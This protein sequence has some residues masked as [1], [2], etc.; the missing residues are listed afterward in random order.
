MVNLTLVSSRGN[1]VKYW[2]HSGFLGLTPVKVE[3]RVCTKLDSDQKLLP[4]KSITVSVRC[5]ESRLG[6]IGAVASN[7]LVD[8]TQVLWSKPDGQEYA[9]IGE[10]EYPFRI[11]LPAHVGGFSTAS[12][13]EYR[14][15]WRVEA[16]LTHVHI[17][18]VG[19]R[20]VK[21]ANLPLVRYDLPPHLPPPQDSFPATLPSDLTRQ[22]SKPRVPPL[23]YC[24]HAPKSPIGP[25]D[26]V[27]IQICLLPCQSSVSI[28]SATLVIERRLHLH[29][30]PPYSAS[31]PIPIPHSSSFAESISYSPL[32]SPAST[33]SSFT[34]TI[35]PCT[36]SDSRAQLLP[37]PS[38]RASASSDSLSSKVTIHPIAAAE[39]TGPFTRTE[40]GLWSK[41]L[42]VQWPA[43]KSSGRW[44]I[45]ETIQSE[46]V[47]V[48]FVVRIKVI[49]STSLGT[50]SLDLEEEE[51]TVVSTNSSERRLALSR[52]HE[53]L[54]ET[55]S[56]SKSPR[57]SRR[58]RENTTPE[59]PLPASAAQLD[60][61]NS[62][63]SPSPSHYSNIP[64]KGKS[65]SRRPHTSA[66]P[67][68]KSSLSFL[69][70]S[71]NAPY[72]RTHDLS[73]SSSS[74]QRSSPVQVDDNTPY[75]RKM[76]PGT[77]STIQLTKS[78]AMGHV[79]S[80]VSTITSTDSG[81]SGRRSTMTSSTT[82]ASAEDSVREWE[83][84]LARI[85]TKSR[86]LS[87]LLGFGIKRKRRNNDP[88]GGPPSSTPALLKAFTGLAAG[89]MGFGYLLMKAT[90]PSEEELYN[91][92][93]PD[94]RKKVDA[95]RELRLAREAELKKQEEAQTPNNNT[96]DPDTIKPIWANPPQK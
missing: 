80:P 90:V 56:K 83:E 43:S 23:R 6:R 40:N 92:M 52:S 13:V 70:S 42:T 28:R 8:Y 53:S 89:L 84:E 22:T 96:V 76:R 81:S 31:T 16:L 66:G 58:D 86:R 93:A 2:P 3:G 39:S 61:P 48:R 26:L 36:P 41:T 4:A 88:G 46:M 74:H 17:V 75:R 68:D 10:S 25:A 77:A 60:H 49:V 38:V 1:S 18:G 37:P 65:V 54:V 63:S 78:N 12:F 35:T 15:V 51:I 91:R 69:S 47:S 20:Q 7:V 14:C 44:G 11:T 64:S 24:I 73:S 19:S 9:E 79:F 87:D 32:E 59:P 95:A 85:E 67:R 82:S 34:S 71:R 94:I 21:H 27:S 45:G 55:R 72:V 29:D 62:P 57:R 30:T 33:S 5:Y 50:D